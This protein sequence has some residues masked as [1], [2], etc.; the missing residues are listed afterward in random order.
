MSFQIRIDFVQGIS[1]QINLKGKSMPNLA[2]QISQLN[3]E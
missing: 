3:A 2:K 1:T